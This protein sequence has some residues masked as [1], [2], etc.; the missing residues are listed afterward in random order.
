MELVDVVGAVKKL[1]AEAVSP[2]ENGDYL[3][4]CNERSFIV[5]WNEA[6]QAGLSAERRWRAVARSF[7]VLTKEDLRHLRRERRMK[8][9]ERGWWPLVVGSRQ[10]IAASA[11][12]SGDIE[13]L[14]DVRFFRDAS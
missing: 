6:W 7:R 1:R 5:I 8:P 3:I 4:V 13:S 12:F 14:S 2:N 9:S 10:P 11:A